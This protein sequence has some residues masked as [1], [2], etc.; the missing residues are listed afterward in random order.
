[1]GP[2]V[3]WQL[4]S[5]RSGRGFGDREDRAGVQGV[6]VT[7]DGGVVG[8]RATGRMHRHPM[9]K[10]INSQFPA[11]IRGGLLPPPEMRAVACGCLSYGTVRQVKE[12]PP[13]RHSIDP[14]PAPSTSR[15]PSGARRRSRALPAHVRRSPYPP[16]IAS[17]PGQEVRADLRG[18]RRLCGGTRRLRV[19]V[20]LAWPGIVSA[21]RRS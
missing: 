9:S 21:A 2:D 18:C 1:V 5:G 6:A 12:E 14:D 13:S 4:F 17:R 20:A 10:Y 3:A 15:P 16:T 8:R 19:G 11:W 7:T